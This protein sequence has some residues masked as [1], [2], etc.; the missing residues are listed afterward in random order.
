MLLQLLWDARIVT[1]FR[2]DDQLLLVR[3]DSSGWFSLPVV[4]VSYVIGVGCSSLLFMVSSWIPFCR[5]QNPLLVV[6]WNVK[7]H[8]LL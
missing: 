2:H 1:Y 7:F 4:P 6:I 3:M 8:S 5:F